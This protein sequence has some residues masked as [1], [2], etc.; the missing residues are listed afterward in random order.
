MLRRLRQSGL[1][2]PGV[3]V[4]GALAVLVSLGAWQWSRKAWKEQL[5][6]EIA[7]RTAAAPVPLAAVAALSAGPA[8]GEYTR[9]RVRGRFDHDHE[10][11]VYAPAGSGPAYHVY[12]PLLLEDSGFTQAYVLVNRGVVPE[13]LLA[14]AAR[15]EGQIAGVV[16]V[17]GLVRLARPPGA[18]VPAADRA[19]RIWYDR[20]LAGMLAHLAPGDG[21]RRPLA[22]YL[23]A[24]A[25]PANPGGWPKGGVT[26]LR[27]PN[28]HLEYA[29]TW[30]GIA[31]TLIGVYVAF[32]RGRL[33]NT[34]R[35]R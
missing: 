35:G 21:A 32:V 13:R 12:T 19:K 23:D 22:F 3:L 9:V 15:P 25:L 20:D 8:G 6:A 4:L 10:L 31:A 28:R 16:E 5:I 27:L 29:L 2:L 14:P 1:L 7:A 24:E 33:A 11:Y 18:F 34:G 30:W 17:A 26:I